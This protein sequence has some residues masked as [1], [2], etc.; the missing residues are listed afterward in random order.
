[1]QVSY[2]SDYSSSFVSFLKKSKIKQM[3]PFHF[4]KQIWYWIH[5]RS[6][7]KCISGGNVCEKRTTK[8][9]KTSTN[10]STNTR[11]CQW[12]R[13][14]FK[15]RRFVNYILNKKFKIKSNYD[16]VPWN[17]PQ[18]SVNYQLYQ[19]TKCSIT[20]EFISHTHTHTPGVEKSK[21]TKK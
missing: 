5:S 2:R 11:G 18:E 19:N 15:L 12:L 16:C 13:F 9:R 17:T 1:M 4:A 14:G 7:A 10:T 20:T 3:F 6:R 8:R 21:Q